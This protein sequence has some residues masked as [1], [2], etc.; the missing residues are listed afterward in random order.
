MDPP[1]S[2]TKN[3]TTIAGIITSLIVTNYGITDT[4]GLLGNDSV[5]YLT[6]T[7]AMTGM[8]PV[9]RRRTAEMLT[10][11]TGVGLAVAVAAAGAA[12]TSSQVE[13]PE[14]AAMYAA[15]PGNESP[16]S[17]MPTFLRPAAQA[18]IE[19]FQVAQR[20][21]S[22]MHISREDLV[23]AA[24]TEDITFKASN[25]DT[26]DLY[27]T[28]RYKEPTDPS[29]IDGLGVGVERP[30]RVASQLDGSGVVFYDMGNSW[31]GSGGYLTLTPSG[32]GVTEHFSA[33]RTFG[34]ERACYGLRVKREGNGEL[35]AHCNE[36]DMGA[37]A[38]ADN[39][40]LA[41]QVGSVAHDRPG[42]PAAMLEL[43]RPNSP[44]ASLNPFYMAF[45]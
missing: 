3:I 19:A 33:L 25:G 24:P 5:R 32:G 4:C 27:F 29:E 26:V 16:S 43:P 8:M 35:K 9:M 13:R 18:V 14:S 7:T 23:F 39:I 2:P 28:S 31:G 21:G 38:L 45:A 22:G 15:E 30:G 12:G 1:M 17:P 34:P 42:S 10:A 6:E 37:M 40:A 11:V 36:Q 20:P 41:R 44:A